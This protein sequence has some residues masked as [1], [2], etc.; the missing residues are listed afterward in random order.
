MQ[1]PT[2]KLIQC[3][4]FVSRG[5]ESLP[6]YFKNIFLVLRFTMFSQCTYLIKPR[7]VDWILS[8]PFH[9][10]LC[11]SHRNVSNWYSLVGLYS[12]FLNPWSFHQTFMYF[13][14]NSENNCR[15]QFPILIVATINNCR[16]VELFLRDWA[17]KMTTDGTRDEH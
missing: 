13:H 11:I 17:F 2:R 9:A 12:H 6:I 1:I 15:K 5:V 16:K 4:L 14:N 7:K 3:C 8:R 10:P